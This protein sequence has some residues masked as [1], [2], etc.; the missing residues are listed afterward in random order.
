MLDEIKAFMETREENTTPLSDAEW[1][2]ELAFLTDATEEINH[3]SLQLQG[4]EKTYVI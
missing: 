3:L 1:L 2:L 4:K